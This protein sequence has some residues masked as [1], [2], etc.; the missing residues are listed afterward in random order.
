MSFPHKIKRQVLTVEQI[1]RILAFYGTEFDEYGRFCCP[2]H[3][4]SNPSANV[5]ERGRIKCFACG[6]NK[7]PHDYVMMQENCNFP[8]SIEKIEEILHGTVQ[9]QKIEFPT[10]RKEKSQV[11]NRDLKRVITFFKGAINEEFEQ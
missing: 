1:F 4:D 8:Q 3:S 9:P 5:T 2:F 11:S 6:V 7:S 10:P